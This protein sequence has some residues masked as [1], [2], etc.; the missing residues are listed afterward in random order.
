MSIKHKF[1]SNYSIKMSKRRSFESG[2][3]SKVISYA[4]EFENKA[5]KRE[6]EVSQKVVTGWRKRKDRLQDMMKSVARFPKSPY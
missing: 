4:E 1:N 5:A 2:F 6:F 3:K